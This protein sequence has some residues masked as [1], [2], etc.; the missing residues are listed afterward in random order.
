MARNRQIVWH[1]TNGIV[2]AEILRSG[3][4]QLATAAIGARERPVAWF[5]T[6][7]F[8][9]PSATRGELTSPPPA[10]TVAGQPV[11]IRLDTI[12]RFTGEEMDQ[13]VG[14]Y[15]IGVVATAARHGWESFKRLSGIDKGLA[16][17]M[18]TADPAVSGDVRHWRASF[19]PVG[20]EHWRAVE[21]LVA[22]VWLSTDGISV[23]GQES[24]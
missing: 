7:P 8:W 4:I 5:S 11:S 19:Q 15:R 20:R 10:D 3:V 9:E 24:N 13:I 6:E 2:I 1:Y 21:R 23:A 18:E 17:S 14:R 22:G 16:R 12:R